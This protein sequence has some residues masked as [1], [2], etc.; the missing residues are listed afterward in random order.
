MKD[1]LYRYD[2]A[3]DKIKSLTFKKFWN[4]PNDGLLVDD[5]TEPVK[6]ARSYRNCCAK[7]LKRM[8]E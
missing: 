1:V 5:E 2:I 7:R 4:K 3:Q 8:V 6:P